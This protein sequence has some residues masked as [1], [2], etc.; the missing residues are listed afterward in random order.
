MLTVARLIALCAVCVLLCLQLIACSPVPM[1]TPAPAAPE[2]VGSHEPIEA[3]TTGVITGFNVASTA[4]VPMPSA[5]QTGVTVK[6][7]PVDPEVL[8]EASRSQLASH[9]FLVVASVIEDA[10]ADVPP[11]QKRIV[12]TVNIGSDVDSTQ[13]TAESIALE[14]MEGDVYLPILKYQ[15]TPYMVG[16]EVSPENG[17]YGFV[18][19]DV[20]TEFESG[21]LVWCLEADYPCE[22]PLLATLP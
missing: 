19:F 5:A 2:A 22:E 10:S 6:V 12:L 13:I 8:D 21:T 17:F 14:S 16:A 1:V 11:D 15:L 9:F 18:A 7:T 4:T 3:G 20:P